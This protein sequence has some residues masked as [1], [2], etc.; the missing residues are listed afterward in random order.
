MNKHHSIID[1]YHGSDHIIEKPLY[2]FGRRDNDYGS[3]F[4]TTEIKERAEEWAFLFG[5]DKA[6]VNHYKL[7]VMGLNILSLDDYGPLAWIAEVISNRGMNSPVG[8]AFTE[9]LIKKYKV[10]TNA[11]DIIVGYRA[12]DSYGDVIE[13]FMSGEIN[14]DEVVRLFYKGELGE[15]VF[16]KS[17]KAFERLKFS[18]AYVPK[19]SNES[20]GRA[21]TIARREVLKFLENRRIEI[22]S[23]FIVP[24][25]TVADAVENTYIYNKEFGYYE[26]R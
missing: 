3:R 14:V 16:I 26:K 9:R 5:S 13:A 2:G 11:A 20:T 22:A 10:D 7:E 4:Y 18:D 8:A 25:I 15:Q 21:I 19:L 24:E 1:I 12:D 6:V 17:E 23:R